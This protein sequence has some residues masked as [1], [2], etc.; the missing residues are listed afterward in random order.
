M[1]NVKYVA[2]ILLLVCFSFYSCSKSSSGSA[3][4]GG[5]GGGT[6]TEENLSIKTDPD[7]G[8]TV[9]AAL[10]AVYD[11]KVN[12]NSKMPPSGVKIDIACTKDADNS[13]VFSQSLNSTASPANISV[14]N[15]L[16]GVLCT[17]KVTVTSL[18]KPSNTATVSFKVAR[19]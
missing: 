10:G 5:G 17:V 15:L 4:G 19:K 7:P 12:I 14:N 3:G 16:A 2:A 11:F 1:K 9:A 6:V 8:A 18:S 13:S